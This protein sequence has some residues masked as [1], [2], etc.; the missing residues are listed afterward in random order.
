[1]SALTQ[2]G[3]SSQCE[4]VNFGGGQRPEAAVHQYQIVAKIFD[5]F[6]RSIFTLRI[7]VSNLPHE[8]RVTPP[9]FLV[10]TAAEPVRHRANK[11]AQSVRVDR[12]IAQ[13]LTH[14]EVALPDFDN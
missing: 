14:I 11:M 8:F 2:S 13:R 10:Q 1:M 3:H 7:L 5:N 6:L 9:Y 12:S 4:S